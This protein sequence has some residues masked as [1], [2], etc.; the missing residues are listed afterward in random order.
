VLGLRVT[1]YDPTIDPDGNGASRIVELLERL[2]V[3]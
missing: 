3:D 2:L 1:I